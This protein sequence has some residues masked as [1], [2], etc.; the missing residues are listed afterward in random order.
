MCIQNETPKCLDTPSSNE[1]TQLTDA[2]KKKQKDSAQTLTADFKLKKFNSCDA[3]EDV[4]KNFIK[5]YYSAHP[6]GA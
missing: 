4:M 5:D 2:E 6:Y 3:M 1:D